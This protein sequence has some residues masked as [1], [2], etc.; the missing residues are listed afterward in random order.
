[1]TDVLVFN[2]L[3][4]SAVLVSPEIAEAMTSFLPRAH[5]PY[6]LFRQFGSTS[7]TYHKA[8]FGNE[9]NLPANTIQ[10][11]TELGMIVSSQVEEQT[12][13]DSMLKSYWH[14]TTL[15]LT[16]A[17]TANCQMACSYCFQSG[18]A[19]SQKHSPELRNS[20]VQ[21]VQQYLNEHPEIKDVHLGLFGGEPLADIDLANAY[22]S[23]LL[24]L[25]SRGQLGFSMS[26]TT[27]GLNLNRALVLDWKDKGLQYIRVTL[28]GPPAI[29]DQRRHLHSGKGTFK[30]I[31]HNLCSIANIDGFGLGVS[32]N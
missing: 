3:I 2:S 12:R 29:H 13:I 17:Y 8:G 18:R 15:K 28:D 30:T 22:V 25:T 5:G 1:M 11:L 21:W 27:N 10:T 16:L 6:K 7:S 9:L 14:P 23:E 31:L 19:L 32:I 24:Q 26:L 4:G 20:T